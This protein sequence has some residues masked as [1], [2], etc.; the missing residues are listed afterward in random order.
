VII[1]ERERKNDGKVSM[2]MFFVAA[3]LFDASYNTIHRTFQS[4]AVI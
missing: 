2:R 3:D 1:E 4:L